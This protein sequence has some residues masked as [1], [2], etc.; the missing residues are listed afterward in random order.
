ML[1]NFLLLF[2]IFTL[3]IYSI[4]IIN[5]TLTM[6]G[7][8]KINTYNGGFP[9]ELFREEKP[10]GEGDYQFRETLTGIHE[11][12]TLNEAF[13]SVR[14]I[15]VLQKDM[16][17]LVNQATNGKV[18]IGKQSEENLIII[19]R[20][21]YFKYAKHLPNE[22]MSIDTQICELN[23][24]VLEWA[25]PNII[26]NVKQYFGYIK[27]INAPPSVRVNPIATNN[28]ESFTLQPDVG[29]TRFM[30]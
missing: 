21:I 1:L 3:E 11:K 25:V 20:S 10:V 9:F 17:S 16:I 24:K 28:K 19:M 15:E 5:T 8:E 12:S 13:F 6:S 14:N 26:T 22:V 4:H 18:T 2:F 23:D 7:R 29:F 27:D 30:K